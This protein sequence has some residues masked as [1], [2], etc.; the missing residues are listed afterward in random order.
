MKKKFKT[1]RYILAS[2]N[3]RMLNFIIDL[4][5]IRLIINFS[6]IL[7]DSL[8][9]NN[10]LSIWHN[11]LDNYETY[12]F[13]SIAM[14]FYYFLTELFFSR[15]LSKFFTQTI[16]IDLNG[17]KPSFIKILARSALRIVPFEQFTFLRGRKQGLH[18]ENS[19]TFVVVKSKL[20]NAIKEYYEI[21]EIEKIK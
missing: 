21:E 18:D 12:L 4:I 17:L 14:F 8:T 9:A 5:L 6:F 16:V 10:Q 2:K 15:S 13:N 1:P 3:I 11:S 19:N 7:L 20:E